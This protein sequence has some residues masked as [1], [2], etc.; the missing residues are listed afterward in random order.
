VRTEP[1]ADTVA[2]RDSEVTLF[3]ASG[4][5]DMPDLSGKDSA[6]AIADLRDCQLSWELQRE[7]TSEVEPNIVIGQSVEA[8]EEIEFGSRVV[9]TVSEAPAPPPTTVTFTP[10]P[11]PPTTEPPPTDTDPTTGGPTDP[12][13]D[14]DDNRGGG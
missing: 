6:E 11:P 5:A 1:E 3:V 14:D 8:G 7:P 13:D 4:S 12:P 2:P 9:L 10:P